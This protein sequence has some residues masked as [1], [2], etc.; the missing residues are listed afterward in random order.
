MGGGS[1]LLRLAAV[2]GLAAATVVVTAPIASAAPLCA[3]DLGAHTLTVT[4]QNGGG[5]TIRANG[6][7]LDANDVDC[8]QL[9]NI[10]TVFIDMTPFPASRVTF[11]LSFGALAPGFTDEGNGTSEIEFQLLGMSTGS[12]VKVIG[13]SSGD[14]IKLGR[15]VD[16]LN[17]TTVG[18]INLNALAEPSGQ[19]AD[20]TFQ[21]FPDKVLVEPGGGN[22]TVAG[23]G[24]AALSGVFTLPIEITDTAGGEDHYTGGLGNDL[25]V[26]QLQS[27][28]PDAWSGGA[29]TDT[30]QLGGG[31]G[32]V[33]SITL[34]DVAND[35]ID[36]PGVSC[37]GA[38]AGADFE[39]VTGGPAN[40]TIAGTAGA[41]VL[42]GG[43][44]TNVLQGLDGNDTLRANQQGVDDFNGGSGRDTLT[45]QDYSL[46]FGTTVT[47]D[48]QA[49]DGLAG[50]QTSNVRSDLEIVF[51]TTSSDVLT[52]NGRRNTFIGLS[53]NDQ[54]FGKAGKDLLV[55]SDHDDTISGGKG[56]DTLSYKGNI[57]PLTISAAA[58]QAS[59][60]GF[61]TFTGIEQI[62]GGQGN[63]G[64]FGSAG[65]DVFKAGPGN[66]T[67]NGGTG[68]D[69]LYGQ[70]GD[71]SFDGGDGTDTCAQGPGSGTVVNCEA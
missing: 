19:D 54:L 38:N 70:Q 3:N 42:T 16:H 22:D 9:N 60:N 64:Y 55:P 11:D 18:Q 61:D 39:N 8:I 43:G 52:G 69:S 7:W 45:F 23:T 57:L 25:I 56:L 27:F 53:G 6:I 4:P 44:G 63:D 40:E 21:A 1:K 29:G 17:Q 50:H 5:M 71:D 49:N 33:A 67:L 15:F 35:G 58:G 47:M 20:V 10:N 28:V 36:C 24:A 30:L 48:G 46:G 12:S 65:N 66:D 59:G 13:T 26:D 32:Q 31:S 62:I 37:A 14:G 68:N 34:D 51:G 2:V 41:N